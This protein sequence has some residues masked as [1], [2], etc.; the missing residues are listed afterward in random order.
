[1]TPKPKPKPK[2]VT[3]TG[4]RL[5][6]TGLPRV[7]ACPRPRTVRL[8]VYAPKGTKLKSVTVRIGK[9]VRSRA[10]GKQLTRKLRL[11]RQPTAPHTVIVVARTTRGETLRYEK[12]YG[13]C[14]VVALSAPSD[15]S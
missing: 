13:S 4:K 12:R 14:F 6:V 3:P 10:K 9:G 2:P 5:R 7:R 8:R 15:S 1:M 11:G